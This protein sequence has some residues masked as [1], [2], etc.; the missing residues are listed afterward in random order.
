MPIIDEQTIVLCSNKEVREILWILTESN[1]TSEFLKEL[2]IMKVDLASISP[3][4]D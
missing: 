2:S 1:L 4:P 3:I